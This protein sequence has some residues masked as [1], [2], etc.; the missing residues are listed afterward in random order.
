LLQNV[1]EIIKEEQIKLGYQRETLRLYYP[2]ASLNKFIGEMCSVEQMEE[3][4]QEFSQLAEEKLGAVGISR[5]GS[6]FCLAVPPQG[7]EYVHEHTDKNEF[8]V[9]FIGV[10]QKHDCTLEDILAVFSKY[11][12]KVHVEKMEQE[13]FDYLIYFEDGVPDNFRY[14]ITFEE[15]HV[16]YHRFTEADY[17]ELME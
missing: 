2:L 15:S 6:R 10:I 1:I 9:Q 8:L 17:E 12:G 7:M 14:C 16:I 11:S 5:K 4:L 3:R 13:E